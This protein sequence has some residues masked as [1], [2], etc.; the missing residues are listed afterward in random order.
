MFFLSRIYIIHTATSQTKGR[1][2]YGHYLALDSISSK[3]ERKYQLTFFDSYGR[4]AANLSNKDLVQKLGIISSKVGIRC[5]TRRYQQPRTKH[6]AHFSIFVLL[7]RARGYSPSLIHRD[8]FG[9]KKLWSVIPCMINNLLRLRGWKT[10]PSLNQESLWMTY[11]PRLSKKKIQAFLLTKYPTQEYQRFLLGMAKKH[12]KSSVSAPSKK[13]KKEARIWKTR[14]IRGIPIMKRNRGTVPPLLDSESWTDRRRPD[15][16]RSSGS[17]SSGEGA[18]SVWGVC[19]RH[20]GHFQAAVRAGEF[21]GMNF[22][23]L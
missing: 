2:I 14:N 19:H 21:L 16:R 4:N 22:D 6:C 17:S 20:D 18:P 13:I 11:Y 1:V 7:L 8:K 5:N 12:E 9:W 15:G 23:N 3:R 10:R